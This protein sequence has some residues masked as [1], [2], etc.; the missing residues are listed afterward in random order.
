MA[1]VALICLAVTAGDATGD[2]TGAAAGAA[3][4]DKESPKAKVPPRQAPPAGNA[5]ADNKKTAGAPQT[6][7]ASTTAV[8]ESAKRFVAD[9]NR[10]DA[11]AA[12][13]AFTPKGVFITENGTRISG[14]EAIEGHFASV[15]AAAPEAHLELHVESVHLVTSNVALEEGDVA[16]TAAPGTPAQ[17]SRYVALHVYQDGRWLLERA[18]DFAV[19]E[20]PRSNHDRLLE[21]EWLVGGWMEE[22]ED[23]FVTTSCRWTDDRNYLL[24]EFT[25]RIGGVPPVTGS[26]RI[27]WD[28]LTRQIKS[29]T[30]DSDGG[31]SEALWTHGTDQWVLK[32]RGVTH[33]GSSFAGTSILRH[34]NENTLSWESR[35]RVEGGVLVP[36]RG[37]LL[38]TRR[39]PPPGE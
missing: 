22:G 23:S 34:V 16:F 2:A 37:P 25:I 15:F 14:R 21:L 32:T 30:F 18:R 8:N 11:R 27:G 28:P 20:A 1:G 12:A 29:W 3:A 17:T 5:K 9:Y 31:Y 4:G 10:H 26:M 24:Q 6:E 33:Q 7:S 13:S 39:P 35:D 19:D 38:V 36:D